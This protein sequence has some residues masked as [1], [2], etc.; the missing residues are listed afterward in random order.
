[1]TAVPVVF[2]D[3]AVRRNRD[4]AATGDHSNRFLADW[5]VRA[6]QDR[7]DVV[8]RKFPAALQIGAL[9]S[10]AALTALKKQAGIETLVQIDTAS[11]P[12][13][14]QPGQCVQADADL[15]PF[16]DSSFDLAFSPFALHTVN[17]LPGALLQ[18]RR[19]LKPD[20]LFVA[21]MAGG[22]TL[23]D[24]RQCLMDAELAVRGGVS[25]RVFPFAGK[26]E[27]GALL[28]R[29]GYALPVVDS[30]FVTVTY[31]SAFKLMRDLRLMGEGNAIANRERGFARRALFMEA[32]RL[33]AER[34]A[35]ADGRIEAR[36][37]IV[38]LLGWSPHAS[39]QKPL[40]PGQ[41]T[42]RLADALGSRE[43][44]AGDKVLP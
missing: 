32:A 35:G 31:D 38:F 13:A 24:L 14:G 1:M 7:L 44:S 9:T 2:D 36:F 16:A 40:R 8:K 11:A 18:I 20:G 39:Q 19:V 37:E 33:Y 4:R 10:P 21:A 34:H 12:L 28:Q 22:E 3:Q 43:Q 29:A 6:L 5:C 27:M 23:H 41:A 17:D 15:L 26:P 30:D 25:P 42:I